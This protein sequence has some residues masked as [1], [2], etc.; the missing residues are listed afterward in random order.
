MKSEKQS[1][2]ELILQLINEQP[3]ANQLAL[4]QLLEQRGYP[5]TQATI[6]R[7]VQKL[8]LVR[9]KTADGGFRYVEEDSQNTSSER[10]QNILHQG[11]VSSDWAQNIVVLKTMPGLA[12]AAAAALDGM[13]IPN[14]VGS[15]AGDD[16]VLLVMRT[17]EAAERFCRELNDRLD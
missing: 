5:V 7:D 4:Q 17:P 12:S 16:T 3:V 14:L 8:R 15:L 13:E 2:Q 10:L 11:A 9:H 1:R 6:S